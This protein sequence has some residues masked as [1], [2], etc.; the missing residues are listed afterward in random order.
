VAE[1][2]EVE[3]E[4]GNAVATINTQRLKHHEHASEAAVPGHAEPASI[5]RSPGQERNLSNTS[6][7]NEEN[8]CSTVKPRYVDLMTILHFTAVFFYFYI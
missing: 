1:P 7:D 4:V 6:S 3:V 8:A 2:L 5:T